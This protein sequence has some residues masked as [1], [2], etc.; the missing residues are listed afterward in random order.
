MSSP[1]VFG[2]QVADHGSSPLAAWHFCASTGGEDIHWQRCGLLAWP[3]P[4]HFGYSLPT[5]AWTSSLFHRGVFGSSVVRYSASRERL[6]RFWP[7]VSGPTLPVRLV[8]RRWDTWSSRNDR[9]AGS[10]LLRFFAPS[11]HAGP[12]AL[13]GRATSRTFPL[14]RLVAPLRISPDPRVIRRSVLSRRRSATGGSILRCLAEWG[15]LFPLASDLIRRRP[16]GSPFAAF[17]PSGRHPGRWALPIPPAVSSSVL[18]TVFVERS[19]VPKTHFAG[20]MPRFVHPLSWTANRGRSNRGFR[21][22]SYR[23]ISAT[24]QPSHFHLR[25]TLPPWALLHWL[26]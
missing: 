15:S 19:A 22:S 12:A 23:T 3:L 1:E 25:S 10:P 20:P 6:V 9:S 17:I 16:W 5:A 14:R 8:A 4:F 26:N 7:R 21:G 11:A 24:L 18:S 2:M 13:S